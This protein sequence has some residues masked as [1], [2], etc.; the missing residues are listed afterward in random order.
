[1]C[2][3]RL[4]SGAVLS[5]LSHTA[6]CH[7][8]LT[9]LATVAV[10]VHVRVLATLGGD[11]DDGGGGGFVKGGSAGREVR[12]CR[13][14]WCCCQLRNDVVGVVPCIVPKAGVRLVAAVVGRANNLR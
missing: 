1:M 12:D 11:D 13:V 3:V 5:V 14:R 4:L 2:D 6:T 10:M 7:M 9:C 8:S